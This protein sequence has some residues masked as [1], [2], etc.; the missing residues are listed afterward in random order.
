MKINDTCISYISTVDNGFNISLN[1]VRHNS[2]VLQLVRQL[3][4]LRYIPATYKI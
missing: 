1:L 2:R 4:G 3:L